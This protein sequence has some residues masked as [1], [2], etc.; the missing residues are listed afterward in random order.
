MSENKPIPEPDFEILKLNPVR[1]SD[2]YKVFRKVSVIRKKQIQWQVDEVAAAAIIRMGLKDELSLDMFLFQYANLE[3]ENHI[4]IPVVI[5]I[6]DE[7]VLP[8]GKALPVKTIFG[9][10]DWEV[11]KDICRDFTGSPLFRQAK[12][13]EI[14]TNSEKE[15][16]DPTP[17]ETTLPETSPKNTETS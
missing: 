12:S 1:P 8:E 3:D 9:D 5:A 15:I 4:C 14:L 10:M 17:L 2:A 11:V 6:L 13:T 16:I 7:L